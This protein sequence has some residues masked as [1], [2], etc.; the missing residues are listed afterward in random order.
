MRELI[1][2]CDFVEFK[3]TKKTKL[4]QEGL[5]EGRM[6]NLIFLRLA[7]EKSDEGKEKEIVSKTVQDLKKFSDTIKTKNILLYPYVHL[8]YGA[9]PAGIKSSIGILQAME[10]QLKQAGFKVMCA[11]FGWY[12]EFSMKCKGHPLSE[13]SRIITAAG[14]EIKGDKRELVSQAV[15]SEEK[16]KS[17]WNILDSKGT[18]IPIKISGGKVSG[19]GFSKYQN[20][21]KFTQYEI[22]KSRNVDKE[23]PHVELMQ[24]LELVDYEPGSD[25]GNV[26]YYPKGNLIKRL[27]ERYVSDQMSAYGAME[28]ETPI[29]YDLEHPT[30]KSYLNRFPARQ[31][32]VKS[33]NKDLFLRFAA[34]F[35]QFLM[36]HDATF[37]YKDMPL[38]LYELTRYSFRA[39]KRGELTGLRR[40]R[41]FTMPDCHALC[42]DEEQAKSELF[43][44]FKLAIELQKGLGIG[45]A[46]LELGIRIV[47]PFWEKNKDYI[48]KLVKE[49]GKPVLVELWDEQFFYFILKY[50]FNFVDGLGKASALTTDQIDIEN[51]KTYDINYIDKNGKKQHPYILHLSP[52]GAIER[53]I[54]TLLEK[55]A[56]DQKA[57]KN[58]SLPLWLSPTQVRLCPVSDSFNNDCEKLADE[59]ST[60]NIR[61]DIDDRQETIGKKVRDSEKE[62]VPYTIV[63]GDREKKSKTLPARYH[64]DGKVKQLS[65]KQLTDEISK[66]T[67][68]MSYLPLN[69]PRNLSKRPIF[70]G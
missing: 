61:T 21:E 27:I 54:Y 65:L 48:M 17:S 23:P 5:K 32:L 56:F 55:A 62:W 4:A 49:W 45:K 20:L 1:Q 19:Y 43:K 24:K 15:K 33:P 22:S 47:K 68:G 52:S 6:E 34:C 46:D 3:A 51:G 40:L 11:P 37:S 50:E 28:V 14:E 53:I 64:K 41:A 13:L 2:H 35:G 12:K 7:F 70:R 60:H 66:Q 29:M 8:L 36:A 31:Y 30:L 59:L 44:R 18:L 10:S 63:Y 57:G 26:R 16:M 25:P 39:E 9:E 58:P 67:E 69:L 38:K 42:T